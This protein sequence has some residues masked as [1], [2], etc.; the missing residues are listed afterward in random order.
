MVTFSI[1]FTDSVTTF[2]K[3]KIS[4]TGKVTIGH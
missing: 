2:L 1:T 4:K 3:S